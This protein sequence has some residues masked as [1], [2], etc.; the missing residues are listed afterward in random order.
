M[1]GT[2]M[3]VLFFLGWLLMIAAFVAAAAEIA[4]TGLA[5]GP[6]GWIGFE[7]LWRALAPASYVDVRL[8]VDDISPWIWHV[9]QAGPL[10]LPGWLLFGLPGVLLAW[11]CRPGRHLTESE[12]EDLRRRRDAL[13]LY[14]ELARDARRQAEED[15]YDPG[16]DDSTPD[17]YSHDLLEEAERTEVEVDERILAEIRRMDGDTRPPDEQTPPPPA[18]PKRDQ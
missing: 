14:D 12:K 4:A 9:L 2:I 16:E 11:F 1:I 3:R 15:G 10:L 8:W 6:A 13:F 7:E 18:Q 5:A 17:H